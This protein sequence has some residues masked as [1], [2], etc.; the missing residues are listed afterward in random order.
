M[1]CV[2][3]QLPLSRKG[4]KTPRKK[5]SPFTF[6]FI[7]CFLCTFASLRE[8]IAAPAPR[9][10]PLATQTKIRAL[11]DAPEMQAGHIGVLISALGTANTPQD[12][13]AAPYDDKTQP[14]LFAQDADKRFLPASNMKLF[15]SAM[16]L[17][18]LGP[19]KTFTT[20]AVHC[21]SPNEPIYLVGSGDPS[22]STSDLQELAEKV[23]KSGT[24]SCGGV[25]ADYSAF[26]A[27]TFGSRYPDG[28][29]LDDTLWYYGP[30]IHALAFNRNQV[31]VTI[32]GGARPGSRA[33]L[34]IEPGTP[35]MRVG[36]EI[37]NN[38]DT[39]EPE[40]SKQSDDELIKIHRPIAQ[41]T[42]D[43][44]ISVEG[45]IAPGQKITLGLAVPV[46]QYWAAKA[47]AT[48]LRDA[49]VHVAG[50]VSYSGPY[51]SYGCR[52][53]GQ[54]FQEIARHESPPVKELLKRLLKNSDNLYAEMMLRNARFNR[55]PK[56]NARQT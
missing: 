7:V 32:T 26:T 39:G 29:T 44:H 23:V 37:S 18:V 11:L 38:V 47:F 3:S 22:F 28:W 13:P 27:E 33:T 17:K 16:A 6:I 12:F 49:G 52:Q 24:K 36:Y 21:D 43:H 46:P 14:L 41:D 25:Q 1:E 9:A 30:V 20:R 2:Y 54:E 48:S 53:N 42:G 5:C 19:E 50:I 31:D 55:C 51:T 45:K 10:L 35:E 56:K 8:T 40:L 34:Q 15:T 4:A